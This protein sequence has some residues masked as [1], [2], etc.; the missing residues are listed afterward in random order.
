MPTLDVFFG[1]LFNGLVFFDDEGVPHIHQ[2][3]SLGVGMALG[4]V[5]I[6][7]GKLLGHI[8]HY[9]AT[10]IQRYQN[11]KNG[12]WLLK[13]RKLFSRDIEVKAIPIVSAIPR[14]QII[15]VYATGD[16]PIAVVDTPDGQIEI[17]LGVGPYL[18][19][20]TYMMNSL[21]KRTNGEVKR[22]E[23]AAIPRSILRPCHMPD[24]MVRMVV[25]DGTFYGYGFRFKLNLVVAAHV[26]RELSKSK[27]TPYLE[28]KCS[29]IKLREDV[30]AARYPMRD[31]ALFTLQNKE[32]GAI[33]VTSAKIGNLRKN[34]TVRVFSPGISP[35]SMNVSSGQTIMGRKLLEFYHTCS[36][37]NGASGS[38]VVDS[39]NNV[40]G[41]HLGS[42]EE[43]VINYGLSIAILKKPPII[44]VPPRPRKTIIDG[45]P[46]YFDQKI[47]SDKKE[48]SSERDRNEM[49]EY[50]FD[51][52]AAE[53]H[54]RAIAA[55]YGKQAGAE[56]LEDYYEYFERYNELEED[57][58]DDGM[59]VYSRATEP[60]R[61]LIRDSF[62]SQLKWRDLD[63]DTL[64]IDGEEAN[65]TAMIEAIS[66]LKQPVLD[67]N[68]VT[69][70]PSEELKLEIQRAQALELENKKIAAKLSELLSA[71][72]ALHKSLDEAR[73]EKLKEAQELRLA[74]AKRLAENLA[75]MEILRQK[76]KEIKERAAKL[77]EEEKTINEELL[78]ATKAAKRVKF[79]DPEPI[80][81]EEDP[82]EPLLL[83][84]ADKALTDVYIARSKVEAI[85]EK[86]SSC[87]KASGSTSGS[88]PP[89]TVPEKLENLDGTSL[90]E[91][92][93]ISTKS[94]EAAVS[95]G[96]KRNKKQRKKLQKSDASVLPAT[97]ALS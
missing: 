66:Q 82:E 32:W 35:G 91:S 97:T 52:D 60:E 47:H 96:I 59:S 63:W 57:Y 34:S 92:P 67:Y 87:L 42:E 73:N 48:E 19:M 20:L 93:K 2:F 7:F 25:E 28:G 44:V 70:V 62:T 31:L 80:V 85:S 4:T 76:K 24:F 10:R 39:S 18:N 12:L 43:G 22:V 23:E 17:E 33:G 26:M 95:Q 58:E 90:L 16:L 55:K 3:A 40:V 27:Q 6:V 53:I 68:N 79:V 50:E 88:V 72:E 51:A 8:L 69:R 9:L 71:N 37:E 38:P 14:Y 77:L 94:E 61:F 13:L 49:W 11:S 75:N 81:L 30:G 86:E 89:I 56:F 36:T 46:T 65:K 15:S 5:A 83:A 29:R 41:I 21:P 64:H 45:V 74:E 84:K 1:E 78:V 54:Y